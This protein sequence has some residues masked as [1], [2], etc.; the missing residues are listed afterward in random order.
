[1]CT[2]NHV[3]NSTFWDNPELEQDVLWGILVNAK[4][5]AVSSGPTPA[6]PV[7]THE[8]KNNGE[9]RNSPSFTALQNFICCFP[10]AVHVHLMDIILPSEPAE[11][12]F[13]ASMQIIC[14]SLK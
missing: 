1:M 2:V 14:L 10:S 12:F 3:C 6:L 8:H 9:W 5:S 4:E 13:K 7:K 11:H